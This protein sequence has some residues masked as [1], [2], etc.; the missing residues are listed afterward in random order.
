MEWTIF[1]IA[2]G[3][4]SMDKLFEDM[5][6]QPEFVEYLLKRI[7]DTRVFQARRFAEAGVDMI[8]IGDDVG[9]QKSLMMS[10]DMYCTW[11]KPCHAAVIRAAKEVNP[12]VKVS[13]HSDGNCIDVIPDLIEIGVDVLNPVQPECLDLEQ[14]KRTFGDKLIFWGGIGTQ[15]TMPFATPDEVYA[16]VTKT[17]D[18]LG[19]TGYYPCPTHVLEPEVSFENINAYLK[20]VGDYR[21][22]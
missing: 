13:Y 4:R 9:T 18:T 14:V 20:A 12:N 2:W 19:P 3:M 15:S 7:T 5:V 16:T 22:R 1:E 21:L 17:I 8:R 11:F 6:C 10:R